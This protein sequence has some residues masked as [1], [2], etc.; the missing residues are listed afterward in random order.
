VIFPHF[1]KI[2]FLD[3]DRIL[4]YFPVFQD[5]SKYPGLKKTWYILVPIVNATAYFVY[6]ELCLNAAQYGIT[7]LIKAPKAAMVTINEESIFIEENLFQAALD[8]K[9]C[10]WLVRSLQVRSN[11]KTSDV[12]QKQLEKFVRSLEPD[13]LMKQAMALLSRPNIPIDKALA[14]SYRQ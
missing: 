8:S 10:F 14:E 1:E 4:E 9:K 3:I 13:D 6:A 12:L 7:K 11:S 2:P 5:E